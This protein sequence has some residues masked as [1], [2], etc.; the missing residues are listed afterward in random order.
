MKNKLIEIGYN[1][2][3][4]SWE[5]DTSI[6]RATLVYNVETDGVE[7]HIDRTHTKS[8]IGSGVFKTHVAEYNVGTIKKIKKREIT[9][10]LA[11]HK[12]TQPFRR[13]GW[14]NEKAEIRNSTL[15]SLLDRAFDKGSLARAIK[16]R[17]I[18]GAHKR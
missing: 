14:H 11:K 7:L 12:Q 1:E 18:I 8:G 6:I 15:S 16:I 4:W 5:Y 2:N 3:Y 13:N 17:S 9:K 10:L